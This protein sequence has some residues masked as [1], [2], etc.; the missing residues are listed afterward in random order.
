MVQASPLCQTG[1]PPLL[2]TGPHNRTTLP[3]LYKILGVDPRATLEQVRKAYRKLA[4]EYHPDVNPDPKAHDRM[5]QINAAFEV[6][7][8]PVRRNEY[9]TSIGNTPRPEPT[10]DGTVQRPEMV[11]ATLIHRHRV[12]KTPVYGASFTPREG[13]LVTASFDNELVWWSPG[14]EG[15]DRRIVLE[16]GVVS[17]LRAVDE[18]TVVAVGSTEQ[19]M[20][21]WTVRDGTV[22]NSWRSTPKAWV[23][24][25]VPSP[26]GQAVAVG[27]LD[28]VLRVLS[29]DRGRKVFE[30]NAHKESVTAVA[31]SADSSLVASGSADATA[32]VWSAKSGKQLHSVEEIRSTVT[33]LAFS[34]SGRWLAVAAVDLSIRVFDLKT[35]KLK[36]KLFGHRKPV[37]ALAFHPKN[38]LLA[39]ASRDG[40]VG[41]WSIQSGIGHGQLQASHQALSCIAFSPKDEYLVAGGLDKILRVW[42]LSLP[43]P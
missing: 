25:T 24:T 43:R 39:S 6:L 40:T 26:N 5:A 31:W 2:D 38:W 8:D 3:K 17:S 19:N 11:E 33:S 1:R 27:S 37:E 32:K 34:P 20:G 28:N 29:A 42:S 15:P 13:R 18:R 21:C 4:R 9:D 16:G 30:G 14:I 10:A 41:L 12:H 23:S 35:Y 36:Q 22:T 7:G